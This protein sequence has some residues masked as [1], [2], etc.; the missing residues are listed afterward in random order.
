MKED[1]V[2]KI[3]EI[4]WKMFQNVSNIGGTALCQQDPETFEIMRFSQAMSWSEAALESYLG[5]LT[6]AEKAKVS[7]L[8]IDRI[9]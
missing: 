3:V 6:A 5:D 7:P 4:E 8:T 9:E 2:A 1:L